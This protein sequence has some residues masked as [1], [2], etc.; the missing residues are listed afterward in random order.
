ME[1]ITQENTNQKNLPP[2]QSQTSFIVS[3]SQLQWEQATN[4]LINDTL[5]WES[6]K[7]AFID[8]T[9]RRCAPSFISKIQINCFW[10]QSYFSVP[11]IPAHFMRFRQLQYHINYNTHR[12]SEN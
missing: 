7:I 12:N 1:T 4:A 6:L 8:T 10:L 9:P 11:I 2:L 5:L 3:S